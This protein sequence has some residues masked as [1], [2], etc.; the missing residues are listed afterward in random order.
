MDIKVIFEKDEDGVV[1]S[2]C[3]SLQGC[4]SQGKTEAE[5]TRN[6]K[7]AIKLHLKCL[8]EDGLPITGQNKLVEKLIKV[9]V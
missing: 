3:P 1:I 9:T 4:F 5:A 2:T 6:I 8:A 7:E